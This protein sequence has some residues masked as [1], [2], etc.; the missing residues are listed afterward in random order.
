MA[1]EDCTTP[2]IYTGYNENGE[3]VVPQVQGY[4]GTSLR[5]YVHDLKSSANLP[6]SLEAILL[7]IS[8]VRSLESYV[9]KKFM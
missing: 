2:H 8:I 6:L 1:L 5:N 7:Y 9:R 3:L 4:T